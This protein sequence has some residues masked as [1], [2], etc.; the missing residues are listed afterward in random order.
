MWRIHLLLREQQKGCLENKRTGQNQCGFTRVFT[1]YT[2]MSCTGYIVIDKGK[3][4][5][6]VHLD[7]QMAFDISQE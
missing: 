7:F 2:V 4:G 1:G 5:F 6:V 3:P